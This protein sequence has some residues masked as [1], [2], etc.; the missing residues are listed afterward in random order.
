MRRNKPPPGKARTCI[1]LG[2]LQSSSTLPLPSLRELDWRLASPNRRLAAAARTHR[3]SSSVARRR[4]VYST[5]AAAGGPTENVRRIQAVK[6]S[7]P[8]DGPEA[9]SIVLPDFHTK[10]STVAGAYMCICCTAFVLRKNPYPYPESGAVEKESISA[11]YFHSKRC[12]T[13]NRPPRCY[14]NYWNSW[15]SHAP[16]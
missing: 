13:R 11:T 10:C 12:A 4:V 1:A 5:A 7:R 8:L 9:E 2:P 14:A 3:P 6:L 15:K 16:Q